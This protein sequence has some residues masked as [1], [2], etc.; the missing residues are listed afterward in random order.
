MTA[1]LR[2]LLDDKPRTGR[3][4]GVLIWVVIFVLGLLAGLAWSTPAQAQTVAVDAAKVTWVNATTLVP[5]APATIGAPIPATGND[6]IKETQ[7][8]RGACNADGTFGVVQQQINVP[9][10]SLSVLFANLPPAKY[11]FRAR[12]VTNTLV[13]SNWSGVGSKTTVAPAPPKT[14]PPTI[15]VG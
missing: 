2:K 10:T 1:R 8:Q 12:H 9:P 11:C 15:T 7:V 5:V 3:Y 14:A 4:L 13:N 6:A